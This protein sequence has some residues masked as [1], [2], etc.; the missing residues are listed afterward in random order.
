MIKKNAALPSGIGVANSVEAID[1]ILKRL[2]VGLAE[3]GDYVNRKEKNDDF[4]QMT[5]FATAPK[6]F[7]KKQDKYTFELLSDSMQSELI[8]EILDNYLDEN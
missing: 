6:H 5:L 2:L 8:T 7:N 4:N 1:N 3:M